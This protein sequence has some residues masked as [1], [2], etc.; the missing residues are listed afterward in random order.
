MATISL[1]PPSTTLDIEGQKW[2]PTDTSHPFSEIYSITNFAD[3]SRAASAL[4]FIW[5][6]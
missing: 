1:F 4:P 6:T 2:Q 3:T 5:G